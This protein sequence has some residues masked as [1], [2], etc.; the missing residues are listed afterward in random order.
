MS[1][2]V[3]NPTGPEAAATTRR[4]ARIALAPIA[5]AVAVAILAA[6]GLAVGVRVAAPWIRVRPGI[7]VGAKAPQ[8]G[9]AHGARRISETARQSQ[10]EPVVEAVTVAV[11][12]ART[13]VRT[14]QLA[15]VTEPVVIAVAVDRRG[16]QPALAGI[17][18]GVAIAV[19]QASYPECSGHAAVLS[20]TGREWAWPRGSGIV[21]TDGCGA[22]GSDCHSGDSSVPP[23]SATSGR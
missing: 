5:P 14:A 7:G 11:A 8:A 13:G 18:D 15:R 1:A 21:P 17:A 20:P 4:R 10:L 2:P 23:G 6:V 9:A 3:A 19:A 12:A 22:A 16:S